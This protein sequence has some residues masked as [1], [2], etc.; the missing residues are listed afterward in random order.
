[1]T[2]E[3]IRRALA[4]GAEASGGYIAAVERI[5]AVGIRGVEYE[6]FDGNIVLHESG[7]IASYGTDSIVDLTPDQL[8][9]DA[10]ERLALADEAARLAAEHG[11]ADR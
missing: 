7:R 3:H 11:S 10:W 8:R 9:E 2:D 5:D 6:S 1:V 4:L